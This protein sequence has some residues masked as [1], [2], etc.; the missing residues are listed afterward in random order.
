MGLW[1]NATLN[2]Y[3]VISEGYEEYN[4]EFAEWIEKKYIKALKTRKLANK[5]DVYLSTEVTDDYNRVLLMIHN[6][7]S[8]VRNHFYAS[9][10]WDIPEVKDD[11]TF[12]Q[13]SEDFLKEFGIVFPDFA[14]IEFGPVG[15]RFTAAS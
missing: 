8:E 13:R 15:K 2:R 11:E 1:I 7:G 3:I 5:Y 14:D 10:L 6:K 12:F 4:H 9:E